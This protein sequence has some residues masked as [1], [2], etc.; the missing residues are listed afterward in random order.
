[1]LYSPSGGAAVLCGSWNVFGRAE[2]ALPSSFGPIAPCHH[3]ASDGVLVKLSY[4][5]IT[6]VR[7]VKG[8]TVRPV[9]SP[10]IPVVI[11][12]R[13]PTALAAARGTEP[14]SRDDHRPRPVWAKVRHE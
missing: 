8:I 5:V 4:V 14:P 1:M 2:A 9:S 13:S 10:H 6:A 7:A 12:H 11:K 3:L